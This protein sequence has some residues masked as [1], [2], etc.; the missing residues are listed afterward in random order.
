VELAVA[1]AVGELAAAMQRA[2]QVGA[3]FGGWRDKQA[4][5]EATSSS[6]QPQ[7]GG[8]RGGQGKGVRMAGVNRHRQ[9]LR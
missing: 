8:G 4:A 9:E 3:D 1:E 6:A 5:W 7:P 2:Y